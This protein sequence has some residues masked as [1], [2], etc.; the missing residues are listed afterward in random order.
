M[1]INFKKETLDT[2]EYYN[3]TWEDV[4]FIQGKDFSIANSKEEFL[5][6]MDFEYD[7]GYGAPE[8]ATDLIIVGED[9]WLERHEY[10]GS[11]WWEYKELPKLNP[12]SKSVKYLCA[13]QIDKA[14]WDTLKELNTELLEEVI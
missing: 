5:K 2:L 13:S 8:I 9:W 1:R 11:E 6:L 7:D 14:G 4:K 10:D 12:C 3:K